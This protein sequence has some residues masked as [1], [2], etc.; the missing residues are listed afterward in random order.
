MINIR[1]ASMSDMLDFYGHGPKRTQRSFAV[2][3]DEQI[4]AIAG[5]YIDTSRL[6]LFS[7]ISEAVDKNEYRY[8]RA[9]IRFFRKLTEIVRGYNLPVQAVAD[10]G[11][12]R[13]CELLRHMGFKEIIDGIYQWQPQQYH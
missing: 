10:P 13:S 12:P 2:V 5:I 7:D 1:P 11:I 9:F 4:I 8:R 3:E 6:V